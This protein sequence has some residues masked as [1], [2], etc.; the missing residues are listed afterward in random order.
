MNLWN[1]LPQTAVE[2]KSMDTFKAEFRFR[3]MRRDLNETYR[4]VKE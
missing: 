2:A 1:S 4:I 3:K